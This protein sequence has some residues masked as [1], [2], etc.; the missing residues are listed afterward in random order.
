M[1]SHT[2]LPAPG[3]AGVHTPAAPA[4]TIALK[5]AQ[6]TLKIHLSSHMSCPSPPRQAALGFTRLLAGA[7]DL[8]LDIPDAAHLLSLFLGKY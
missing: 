7:D 3:R 2:H 8:A 1:L 4:H 5:R 6:H